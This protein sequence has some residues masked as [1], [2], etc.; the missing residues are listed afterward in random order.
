MDVFG[1]NYRVYSNWPKLT[2]RGQHRTAA[3]S[4]IDRY[5]ARLAVSEMTM[6]QRVTGQ[7]GQQI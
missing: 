4:D 5:F 7:V 3:S 6:G 1:G 2:H